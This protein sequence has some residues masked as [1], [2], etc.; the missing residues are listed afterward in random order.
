M[1]ILKKDVFQ[2][3]LGFGD[4]EIFTNFWCFVHN[5]GYRYARKSFK[6]SKDVDFGLV[7]KKILNH[8]NSPMGWGPGPGKG[9]QIHPHLWRSPENENLFFNLDYKTC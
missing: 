6:V 1:A 7:S 8:N 9:S 2:P 3:R 5:F 4:A